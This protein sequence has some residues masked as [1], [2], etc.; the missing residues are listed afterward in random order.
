PRVDLEPILH[1]GGQERGLRS[2]TLP[3]P[4][5]VGFG[6]AVARLDRA[7]VPEVARLRDGLLERLKTVGDVHLN[8]SRE[9]RVAGNLNVRI[10]G[11]D[12]RALMLAVRDVAMSSG[13]AC[14]SESLTPSHV[15]RAMGLTPDEAATSVRLGLGLHTTE[16]AVDHAAEAL[17]AGI[18]TVRGL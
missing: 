17:I 18:T 12:V 16:E 8:G 11:V 4:L 9:H 6:E 7:R 1:C 10:G 3:V 5:V 14:T 13:S 15:L 2:G